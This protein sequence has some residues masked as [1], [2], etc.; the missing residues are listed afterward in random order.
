MHL[1]PTCRRRQFC[2]RDVT[3]RFSGEQEFNLK[4][5][6]ERTPRSRKSCNNFRGEINAHAYSEL[7]EPTYNRI[8]MKLWGILRWMGAI[9][10]FVEMEISENRKEGI[11]IL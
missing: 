11:L 2:G 9:V 1:L 5:I 7:F 8:I 4:A 6:V 3:L 10:L